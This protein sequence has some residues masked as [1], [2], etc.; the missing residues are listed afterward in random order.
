MPPQNPELA[1]WFAEEIQ[2]HESALR[3]FLRARFPTLVDI[4]DMVQESYAR[5]LQVRE[6]EKIGNPKSY[7]FATARNAALD[8][9]RQRRPVSL[10][11]LVRDDDQT[12]LEDRSSA[13]DTLNH[14][15]ELEIL[16]NAIATLPERC[17][18]VMTLQKIH[19]L[20]NREIAER[21]GISIHTVNAHMVIGLMR[22]RE[23][24]KVR[25]V[26]RGRRS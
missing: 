20:S 9:F 2:P 18:Q 13:A 16:M 26:L 17:R 6:K 1:R 15:Q 22:C 3:A 24:L 21:L 11:T 4:D 7:L 12:V 14:A 19:G 8:F 23:Y 10:E 25:G 5:L